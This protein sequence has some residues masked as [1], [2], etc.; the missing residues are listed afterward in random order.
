MKPILAP[1]VR[2]GFLGM[3]RYCAQ[4]CD[5]LYTDAIF[6]QNVNCA[7]IY[8]SEKLLV[9]IRK[10]IRVLFLDKALLDKTVV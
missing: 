2:A 3:Q 9:L 7:N 1:M 8:E 4:Y 6:A 10:D 5:L